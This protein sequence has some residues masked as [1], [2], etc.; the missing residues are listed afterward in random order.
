MHEVEH[1]PAK[2]I[3]ESDQAP[4]TQLP[5]GDFASLWEILDV[6]TCDP[7]SQA[8]PKGKSSGVQSP[9]NLQASVALTEQLCKSSLC[10]GRDQ[11]FGHVPLPP[12]TCLEPIL[13]MLSGS[14]MTRLGRIN[15]K[16]NARAIEA[17]L[18]VSAR[19]DPVTSD[20]P[21]ESHGKSPQSLA[22]VFIGRCFDDL[23]C[24]RGA[25]RYGTLAVLARATSLVGS[26]NPI[27]AQSSNRPLSPEQEKI[28]TLLVQETTGG[29]LIELREFALLL[30]CDL[31]ELDL[32]TSAMLTTFSQCL[33][34]YTI[35][36][37]KGDVGSHMR[38]VAIHAVNLVVCRHLAD[39]STLRT[40]LIAK[41]CG[42]AVEKLDRVRQHA[43]ACLNDN[44]AAC[45]LTAVANPYVDILF[46]TPSPC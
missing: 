38:I 20:P 25:Q 11:Y 31:L 19:I 27:Y 15:A 30:L 33:Y 4:T 24:L 16:L 46:H 42:L 26:V 5:E 12:T 3:C 41:V 35:D 44:W 7:S 1:M 28:I 29:S 43:F 21:S 34:D 8:K 22:N 13:N 6:E 17:V 14:R 2:K 40:D 39:N 9:L 45:G 10:N 23:V 37:Q 18:L 32:C 36:Q